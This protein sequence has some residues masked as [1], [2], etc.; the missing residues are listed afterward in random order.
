MY[1][2]NLSSTMIR[3][4]LFTVLIW[5]L[6]PKARVKTFHKSLMWLLH[7]LICTLGKYLSDHSQG[8]PSTKPT[9]SGEGDEQ[10]VRAAVLLSSVPK[11]HPSSTPGSGLSLSS[12]PWGPGPTD[13]L[14]MDTTELCHGM[15][16]VIPSLVAFGQI[17]HLLCTW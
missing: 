16:A 9:L 4:S 11:L 13:T 14:H 15:T 17:F 1:I 7:V 8:Q 5:I 2:L 6:R 3:P 12:F 10:D